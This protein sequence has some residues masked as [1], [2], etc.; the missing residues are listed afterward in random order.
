[1]WLTCEQGAGVVVREFDALQGYPAPSSPRYV[2]S[3]I[4]T[5]Q[6]RIVASYRDEAFYDGDRNDGYGGFTYDGRWVPI[7]KSMCGFYDLG[8][9]SSVLQVNCEKGFLLHDFVTQ[10]PGIVVSGTEVSEYAIQTSMESVR[11]RISKAP[12]TSL[13][14]ADHVFDLV[15]GIGTVYALNLQDAITS[16]REIERVGR[17]RSFVTLAAYEEESDKRLFEWWT[18]LGTT[19]LRKDEWL[20]VLRHA[21]YSGDYKFTTAE[22]LSLREM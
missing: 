13:P 10:I 8:P 20:E 12:P 5:I 4:R 3:G 1:M 7:V 14:Y 16:L 22:S 17:G 2:G 6:N 21:D 15:I 18:L 19:L 11:A 9:K